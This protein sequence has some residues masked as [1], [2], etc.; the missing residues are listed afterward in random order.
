MIYRYMLPI[1]LRDRFYRRES[2]YLQ[3]FS[4]QQ[5]PSVHYRH[6]ANQEGRCS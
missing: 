3:E 5:N 1:L 4:V 2:T 6:A